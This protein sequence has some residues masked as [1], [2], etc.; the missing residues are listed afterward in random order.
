MAITGRG[1]DPQCFPACRWSLMLTCSLP[2]QGFSLQRS[3]YT[4]WLRWQWAEGGDLEISSPGLS[5]AHP[6]SSSELR[7]ATC[8]PAVSVH[9]ES[10]FRPQGPLP[11]GSE[12]GPL[13]TNKTGSRSPAALEAT[14]E[15][16]VLRAQPPG[17][18]QDTAHQSES[19]LRQESWPPHPFLQT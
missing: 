4:S 10:Y 15:V 5:P 16:A 12:Q 1:I 6:S 17:G 14:T 3:H 11:L 2:L 9:G 7:A 13:G 18:L 19:S 8:S